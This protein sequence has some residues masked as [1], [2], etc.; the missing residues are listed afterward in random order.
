MT[1]TNCPDLDTAIGEMEFDAVRL[2]RLQ[3][4]V[5]RCDPI[6]DYSTL[7]ARKVDMADAEERFRLRGEKL[8]L[9]ADRRLAGRALLLVVEQAHSLRRAR[10][11][12]P[13]VRE[14]STALTIITESAARDRDEAEASRVLAEHD[15]VTASF[16]AAAGEASLTYL[17]LSAAPP[18]TSTHKDTGHG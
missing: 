2:R 10:R 8:R 13:T 17:R 4:Q 18:T 11:R 5:A 7:T 6:K 9:D 15:R 16:K 14:L 3:A 1:M 12:K